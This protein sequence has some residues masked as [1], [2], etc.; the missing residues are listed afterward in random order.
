MKLGSSDHGLGITTLCE[1]FFQFLGPV[2][3]CPNVNTEV[4][5]SWGRSNREWVP[6]DESPI[7]LRSLSFVKSLEMEKK[8]SLML[9]CL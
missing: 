2:S 4:V 1:Y 8:T 5:I 3:D 7:G 9:C 6:G